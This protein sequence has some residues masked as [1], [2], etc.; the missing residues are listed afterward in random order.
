LTLYRFDSTFRA[1]AFPVF[2]AGGSQI[3]GDGPFPDKSLLPHPRL[4]SLE[5]LCLDEKQG[6]VCCRK[7]SLTAFS[8]SIV[9]D[10][11]RPFPAKGSAEMIR[12][13]LVLSP[14]LSFRS[15]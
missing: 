14:F 1:S 13:W 6:E 12:I 10:E 3:R 11:L 8:L 5:R 15:S 7:A 2:S 9:E 4:L